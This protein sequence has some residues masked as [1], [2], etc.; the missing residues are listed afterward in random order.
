[1]EALPFLVHRHQNCRYLL[2]EVGVHP[3]L[4]HPSTVAVE[5]HVTPGL[6]VQHP[7][8]LSHFDQARHVLAHHLS[9]LSPQVH[10]LH[11]TLVSG[12]SGLAPTGV[13]NLTVLDLSVV[14]G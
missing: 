3:L 4:P 5:K 6:V 7:C 9:T 12:N 14:D 1:M 13:P 2:S 11:V 8:S 10:R